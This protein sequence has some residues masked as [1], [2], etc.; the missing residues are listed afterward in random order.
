[1]QSVI[2]LNVIILSAVAPLRGEEVEMAVD[3]T[4]MTS[5]TTC[6]FN[7]LLVFRMTSLYE[8]AHYTIQHVS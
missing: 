3:Q 2:M 1:M 8:E 4:L 5:F 7:P 6:H